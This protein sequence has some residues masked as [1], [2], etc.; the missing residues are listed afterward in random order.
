MK[1]ST[2][3]IAFSFL[4]LASKTLNAQDSRLQLTMKS[5]KEKYTVGEEI[6]L[7][8]SVKNVSDSVLGFYPYG[9]SSVIVKDASVL[10]QKYFDKVAQ[11]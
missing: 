6:Q 3:V 1:N 8:C 11:S 9:P 7:H 4:I 2:V 5:D 10:S